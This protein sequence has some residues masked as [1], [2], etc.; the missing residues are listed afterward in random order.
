[1]LRVQI[2]HVTTIIETDFNYHIFGFHII[3]YL[4]DASC[5]V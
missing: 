1:M 2:Y 3:F 4:R 5:K